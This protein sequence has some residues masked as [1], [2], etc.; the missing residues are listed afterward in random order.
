MDLTLIIPSFQSHSGKVTDSRSSATI[1]IIHPLAFRY[2]EELAHI[3]RL[4]RDFPEL[5]PPVVVSYHWLTQ[6]ASTHTRLDPSLPL[7][8]PTPIFCHPSPHEDRRPLRVWVSVNVLR[9]A[10]EER[11]EEA[12]RAVHEKL[13]LGGGIIVSKRKLADLLVIDPE[14]QFY[15]NILDERKKNG[16]T[17]QRLAERDWVEDCYSNRKLVWA[18][19]MGDEKVKR[20]SIGKGKGKDEDKDDDGADSFAEDDMPA[21]SKGL[22]RPTGQ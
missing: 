20:K 14:T 5:T 9:Q 19:T 2:K 15:Q 7:D 12:Q 18:T 22:G 13:A 4:A 6:V 8:P 17:D 10:G 1:L 3:D 16:R 21:K 11:A